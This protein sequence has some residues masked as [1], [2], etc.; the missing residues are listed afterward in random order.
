MITVYHGGTQMAGLMNSDSALQRLS[1]HQPN[2]RICLLYQ[3]LTD[4]YLIYERT[5]YL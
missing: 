1:M 2:N 4:K 5:E 3:H